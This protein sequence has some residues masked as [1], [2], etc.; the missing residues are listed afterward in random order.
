MGEINW[1]RR[2]DGA[3]FAVQP[4]TDAEANL[5]ALGALRIEGPGKGKADADDAA[6]SSSEPIGDSPAPTKKD[7]LAAAAALGIE[8]LGQRTSNADIT[9][10]IE[11][12]KA[13]VE[14]EFAAAEAAKAAAAAATPPT[15]G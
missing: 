7:L 4:G 13:E 11:V 14:A 8:G 10:A 3:E 15:E 6:E 12:K 9:A 1:F 2:G 5:I